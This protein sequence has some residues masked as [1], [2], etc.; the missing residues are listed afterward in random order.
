[1]SNGKELNWG[2]NIGWKR[3]MVPLNFLLEERP[4]E[5]QKLP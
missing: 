4:Q 1:L 5:I 2:G 3:M